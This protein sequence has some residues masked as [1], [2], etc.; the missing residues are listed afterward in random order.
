M[1]EK[2][3]LLEGMRLHKTGFCVAYYLDGFLLVYICGKNSSHCTLRQHF[4]GSDLR[5]E[6]AMEM[7]NIL[8][9]KYRHAGNTKTSMCGH[10]IL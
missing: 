7:S 8:A 1:H 6:I 10:L 9:Q 4:L 3:E 5:D 2:V